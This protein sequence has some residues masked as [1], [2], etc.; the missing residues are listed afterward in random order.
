[1]SS[2]RLGSSVACAGHPSPSGVVRIVME[3]VCL[4]VGAGKTMVYDGEPS[5]AFLM[6]AAPAGCTGAHPGEEGSH[7]QGLLLIDCGLGVVRACLQHADSVPPLIYVSHNHTDHAGELPVVLAVER[8]RPGGSRRTVVTERRVAEVLK[9]RRLH[10]TTAV[11]AYDADWIV[12]EE[13]QVTPIGH[14]L[15]MMPVGPCQHTELCFG[16]V[17]YADSMD[18]GSVRPQGALRVHG[19][20]R[21]LRRPDGSAGG[22]AVALGGCSAGRNAGARIF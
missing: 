8:T 7:R 1:L 13:G 11:G 18:S 20:Q 14:G 3:L 15:A 2:S 4:G 6:R 22:G 19:G 21:P 9:E 16:F 10:E 5:S 17:L 12:L